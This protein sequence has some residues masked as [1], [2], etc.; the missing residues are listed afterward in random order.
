[1]RTIAIDFETA[2]PWPGNACAMGLAWIEGGRVTRVEERL[3]RPR[4]MTFHFTWIHG[5]GPD[6]VH[7]SPEFPEVFAEFR[8]ELRGALLLAHNAPFDAGVMR[9]CAR[10]YRMR[11]PRFSFLCTLGIA[12]KVWPELRSKALDS[13]ARH[14]GL[15]FRHHNA[16]ED[17]RVCAEIALAAAQT[18]GALEV[19]DLPA[20]L[21][22]WRVQR[23]SA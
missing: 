12:R 16:A 1:M 21:E 2:N 6:D 7:G 4:E 23:A 20:R 5:I 22:V 17:A 10:A 13:V 19:A 9:G 14:L 15:R 3:I 18:V 11:A 8:T